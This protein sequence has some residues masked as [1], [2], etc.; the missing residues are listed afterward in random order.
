MVV[1]GTDVLP[2]VSV[3]KTSIRCASD[4][5]KPGENGHPWLPIQVRFAIHC[6]VQLHRLTFLLVLAAS[7]LIARAD[8]LDQ[9]MTRT[10]PVPVSL[11]DI[12]YAK[13]LFVAVGQDTN[14]HIARLIVSSNGMDW[15]RFA[16]FAP[17]TPRAITYG[18]NG[19]FV[20]VG[21]TG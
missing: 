1:A 14:T 3:A 12:V 18:S 17:F 13:G 11:Y 20:A 5:H 9:W 15:T 7:V 4:V 16:S 2:A 21:E 8:A 10:S 6:P 19:L